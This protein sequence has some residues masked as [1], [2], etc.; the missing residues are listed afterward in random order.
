MLRTEPAATNADVNATSL[1]DGF[2]RT[3]RNRG[4]AVALRSGGSG[5]E[6][7]WAEYGAQVRAAASALRRLGV[8]AGDAVALMLSN[9]PEFH[10]IDTAALHLGAIPFSIYNTSSAGQVG[11][12]LARS[13]AT[14]IVTESAL[15]AAVIEAKPT[16]VTVLSVDDGTASGCSWPDAVAAANA[17]F[18]LEAAAAE[19]AV[20][21]V[22]TLIYTSGTTG[23]PKAVEL[24]HGNLL[25]IVAAFAGALGVDSPDE[26]LVSY[27]PMAHV[28][29]RMVTHYLPIASGAEVTCCGDPRAVLDLLPTARPTFFFAP[30]RLLEKIQAGVMASV[31]RDPDAGRGAAIR[32]A[33]ALGRENFRAVQG[34]D[35]F[36]SSNVSN[37]V[38]LD[39][40]LAGIREKLG[41]DS[42]RCAATGAA[43]APV[44]VLEFM[45]AIGV[46]LY[47]G[48]GMSETGG[49]V[50]V[51]RPGANRIGTVGQVLPGFEVKLADDGELLVK[52]PAVMRGYRD[53][54]DLTAATFDSEGWLLT[55]DIAEI[56]DDF[57]KIVDR[58]KELI[59]TSGGKNISPSNVEAHL[60]AASPLIGQACCIGDGRP[61]NVALIVLDPDGVGAL[62]GRFGLEEPTLEAAA[63]SAAIRSVVEHAVSEANQHLSRAEQ[64]KKFKILTV[65]WEPD[66]DELTPTVK[67]KR[68]TIAAKYAAEIDLLYST[69]GAVAPVR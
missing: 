62:R 39:P 13:Q 61:Y 26:R 64:I 32:A 67:L 12:L 10:V 45:G 21:D 14:V 25:A 54:P 42:I 51:N 47:E 17:D 7:T 4:A 6:I 27:L 58:K 49:S 55:G 30:P 65:D 11:D 36:G 50:S 53:R 66:G 29:E 28:A 33:I 63:S 2:L 56:D 20:D 37:V 57:I 31:A 46:P 43:P 41:F 68:R 19:V 44:G 60:K 8:R 34:S 23:P 38:E 15:S 9:R 5:A 24:T 52:G 59:I 35:Q 22:A 18:D 1:C 48:Y 69:A 16:N 40:L 3:V